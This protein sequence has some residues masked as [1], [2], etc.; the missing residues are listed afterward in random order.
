VLDPRSPANVLLIESTTLPEPDIMHVKQPHW[1]ALPVTYCRLPLESGCQKPCV[2]EVLSPL[3]RVL[4]P[5]LSRQ[6]QEKLLSWRIRRR[7]QLEAETGLPEHTHAVQAAATSSPAR[8][9]TGSPPSG[10][11]SYQ[12]DIDSRRDRRALRLANAVQQQRGGSAMSEEEAE[13][14]SEAEFVAAARSFARVQLVI[15]QPPPVLH[16]VSGY[17]YFEVVGGTAVADEHFVGSVPGVSKLAFTLTAQQ[18][19]TVVEASVEVLHH[20]RREMGDDEVFYVNLLRVELTLRVHGRR[21]AWISAAVAWL[22]PRNGQLLWWSS[23]RLT[24]WLVVKLGVG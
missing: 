21:W 10:L 5:E 14:L 3:V 9:R 6:E 15:T 8:N 16:S 22:L 23:T 1:V 2:A 4:A 12:L 18:P 20:P 11:G 7:N 24:P 13:Q 19:Q 17:L